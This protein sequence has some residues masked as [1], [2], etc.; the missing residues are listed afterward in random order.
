MKNL[1]NQVKS[2]K[3][4]KNKEQLRKT[5][6]NKEIIEKP[7][8]LHSPW[9]ILLSQSP[10]HCMRDGHVCAAASQKYVVTQLIY[11]RLVPEKNSSFPGISEFLG[12]LTDWVPCTGSNI[13]WKCCFLIQS[14]RHDRHIHIV[15][16]FL[17]SISYK[18]VRSYLLN[19]TRTCHII[20]S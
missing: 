13:Y 14:L 16:V 12:A 11:K 8:F 19:S 18:A 15:F 10:P 6:N 9:S 5:K 1:E 3:T 20:H 17:R 4:K 7:T 2:W